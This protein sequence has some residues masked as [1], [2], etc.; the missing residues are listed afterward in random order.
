MRYECHHDGVHVK[1]VE[2][3]SAAYEAHLEIGHCIIAMHADNRRILMEDADSISLQ[4][5]IESIPTE[6]DD[7]T[8]KVVQLEVCKVE[9]EGHAADGFYSGN[10]D[11]LEIMIPD[12]VNAG[13]KFECH[14]GDMILDVYVPDRK[15]SGSLSRCESIHIVPATCLAYAVEHLQLYRV[16]TVDDRPRGV[17][18]LFPN[19]LILENP[20]YQEEGFGI[21]PPGTDGFWKCNECSQRIPIFSSDQ[22]V[23][24][25]TFSRVKSERNLY[26]QV[27]IDLQ[28]KVCEYLADNEPEEK[29]K[30][31]MKS[32]LKTISNYS[33]EVKKFVKYLLFFEQY[34]EETKADQKTGLKT[35][36]EALQLFAV[37]DAEDN[38]AKLKMIID[39]ID[40]TQNDEAK[41]ELLN[42]LFERMSKSCCQDDQHKIADGYAIKKV[43]R[44]RDTETMQQTLDLQNCCFEC[45]E[46]CN[47]RICGHCYLMAQ[48]MPFMW[49]EKT[50]YQTLPFV[51]KF[52]YYVIRFLGLDLRPEDFLECDRIMMAADSRALCAQEINR[53]RFRRGQY[54]GLASLQDYQHINPTSSKTILDY[55][56]ALAR[57]PVKE[58]AILPDCGGSKN[59]KG[60]MKRIEKTKKLMGEVAQDEATLVNLVKTQ[61]DFSGLSQTIQKQNHFVKKSSTRRRS[62]SAMNRQEHDA[63]LLSEGEIQS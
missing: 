51:V 39:E 25:D 4:A 31:R 11:E 34:D 48:G 26:L 54:Q 57:K 60:L 9:H 42:V 35:K 6:S 1:E 17:V 40:S 55:Q 27:S 13:E 22:G 30:K 19:D 59:N 47:Y 3:E 29:S 2:A 16:Q 12:N 58:V 50:S 38:R 41:D 44:N 36:A 56:H 20:V 15:S 18:S 23:V 52:Q 49:T 8:C 53:R 21:E 61:E 10:P 63:T 5:A 7:N 46:G 37:N 32:K 24:D 43:L 62:V 45:I 28:H 33:K 14:V